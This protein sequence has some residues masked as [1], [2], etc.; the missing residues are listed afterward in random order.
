M[1]EPWWWWIEDPVRV[2]QVSCRDVG[3][4]AGRSIAQDDR[5]V[6]T[7]GRLDPT[8][9]G[10]LLVRREPKRLLRRG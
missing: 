7:I 6:H 4:H 2:F 3:N 5:Y 9:R 8:K 10:D 1:G